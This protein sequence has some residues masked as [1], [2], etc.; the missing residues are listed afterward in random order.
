M[1]GW[2]YVFW[3]LGISCHHDVLWKFDASSFQWDCRASSP[4]FINDQASL[5]LSLSPLDLE[6]PALH[7]STVSNSWCL[8]FEFE[9]FKIVAM[10]FCAHFVSLCAKAKGKWKC[11]PWHNML[12]VIFQRTLVTITWFVQ[13]LYILYFCIS[14]KNIK[15]YL[16]IINFKIIF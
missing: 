12:P 3:S 10:D 9:L 8:L 1:G 13:L 16:K 14:C 11:L 6:F 4:P 5:S 7:L 2:G 15:K